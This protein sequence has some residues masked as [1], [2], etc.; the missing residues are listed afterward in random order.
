MT[1]YEIASSSSLPIVMKH[2]NGRYVL[3]ADLERLQ[4]RLQAL[5]NVLDNLVSMCGRFD[6]PDTEHCRQ[7]NEAIEQAQAALAAGKPEATENEEG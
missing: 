3:F 4:Q 5:E 7:W 1:R 6:D 2:P